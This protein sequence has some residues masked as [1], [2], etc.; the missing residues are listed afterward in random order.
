MRYLRPGSPNR[1]TLWKLCAIVAILAVGSSP[2]M[3]E[4]LT[5]IDIRA[6]GE[7]D[8]VSRAF[9]A[10][11]AGLRNDSN[12]VA[13][14]GALLLK[15]L[16]LDENELAVNQAK[17]M[18]EKNSKN[19]LAW[20]TLAYVH[21]GQDE[22]TKAFK[23]IAKAVQFMPEDGFVQNVAGQLT[24]WYDI[25]VRTGRD[26]DRYRDTVVRIRAKLAD[27]DEFLRGYDD[28]RQDLTDSRSKPESIFS[29]E[30]YSSTIYIR[31]E[32][33][34][35]YSRPWYWPLLGSVIYYSNSSNHRRDLPLRL[36]GRHRPRPYRRIV[37]RRV[38]RPH[39]LPLRP[40]S[41]FGGL[42]LLGRNRPLLQV[43]LDAEKARLR[44]LPPRRPRP[45]LRPTK[46]KRNIDRDTPRVH[47]SDRSQRSRAVDLRP[48][49]RRPNTGPIIS[50]GFR[51]SQRR[52]ARLGQRR[53]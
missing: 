33:A 45:A 9:S 30:D 48:A 52:S 19:G 44:A 29:D 16:A 38:F 35:V 28:A 21:A 26:V 11:A 49:G 39:Y 17:A 23:A 43:R 5:D 37:N 12:S 10:Y 40:R 34:V 22:M 25:Q 24:A 46:P 14:R 50:S 18:L 32:G 6:I 31:N 42:S 7:A 8:T 1:I 51:P 4:R 47:R 2:A 36:F 53:R 15:L 13:L 20:A 3:A 41:G 27:R